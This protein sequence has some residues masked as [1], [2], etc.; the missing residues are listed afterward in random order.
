MTR[1]GLAV[2]L[3][4][5]ALLAGG[6]IL[7][8][9][10]QAAPGTV[11]LSWESCSSVVAN[12]ESPTSGPMTLVVSEIGNDEEQYGYRVVIMFHGPNDLVPDAWRF[13]AVGCHSQWGGVALQMNQL[14]SGAISKACPAFQGNHPSNQIREVSFITDPI[15]QLP[16][17]A[18]YYT[19]P[20][21]WMLFNFAN[22]YPQ[23]NT[24]VASQRYHLVSIVMDHTYSASGTTSPGVNCGGFDQPMVFTSAWEGP[25]QSFVTGFMATYLGADYFDHEFLRGNTTLTVHGSL[26]AAARTWGQIKDIYRR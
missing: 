14:P 25:P 22:L 10:T 7:P 5:V 11:D 21:T 24:T 4:G 3:A 23:G 6:A 20:S 18:G 1:S 26:P 17:A 15:S 19:P 8:P 16:G 13:D 12:V 9:A 2:V